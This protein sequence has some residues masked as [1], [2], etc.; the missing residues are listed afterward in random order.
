MMGRP[1][2]G[3]Y[4]VAY[5]MLCFLCVILS[6]L[7]S[8][9]TDRAFMIEWLDPAGLEEYLEPK[10]FNWADLTP[11]QKLKRGPVRDIG[12]WRSAKESGRS[13]QWYMTTNFSTFFTNELEVVQGHRYD[14][15]YAI[16]RNPELMPKA[17]ELGVDRI[18]C[19]ICCAFHMLFRMTEKFQKQMDELLTS[20]GS[21]RKEIGTIQLRTKSGN[22]QE[23]VKFADAFLKCGT[24]AAKSLK[25]TNR[26]AWVP[27]FNNRLVVHIVQ[28]KYGDKLKTPINIDSATR[29]VHTHLGN[30]PAD[31]ELEVAK[32][33]Q[34]RTF[35]EFFLM[36][37]STIIIRKKGY[38]ASFGNIADAI[39]RFYHELGTVHTYLVGSTCTKFPDTYKIE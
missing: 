35:K 36:I 14:F 19:R 31:T 11:L 1:M 21:P 27:I 29:T 25:L 30:L 28:K 37:N 20:L 4:C 5:P 32:A 33:V 13:S 23:A 18:K 10:S 7:L 24:K 6:L 12:S 38:E 3:M 39:R 8:H 34:E 16:L 9:H 15:T 22:V 17:Y 26:I 2:Y